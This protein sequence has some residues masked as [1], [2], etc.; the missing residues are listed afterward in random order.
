M[1][2]LLRQKSNW[3][4]PT[5]KNRENI[6]REALAGRDW[7]WILREMRSA[8]LPESRASV[9][10]LADASSSPYKILVST[11][12]SLRTRDEVTFARSDAL[13]KEA[14]VLESLQAM[15]QEKLAKLIYPAA[16]YRNKAAT[17]KHIAEILIHEFDGQ[18][19]AKIDSL[20]SLPGV[21]RKTATLVLG[22]GFGIPAICVDA[23]V[24]RIYQRLGFGPTKNPDETER[25]LEGELARENWIELNDCM[26]LFGQQICRPLSPRCSICPFRDGC[27]RSG[28]SRSR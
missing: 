20:L 8:L 10:R 17:L 19:P 4:I 14:P 13:F 1:T 18:V 11:I 27:P 25:A 24:H 3:T 9:T 15:D 12:I 5:K 7:P 23:H 6:R 2:T 28:V 21:G 26:V 22:L 16:F